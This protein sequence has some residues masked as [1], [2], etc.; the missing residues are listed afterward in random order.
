MPTLRILADGRWIAATPTTP[1]Y[2]DL[3]SF[4]AGSADTVMLTVDYTAW[5]GASAMAS[6]VW[7]VTGGT[8]VTQTNAAPLATVTV[9]L[10]TLPAVTDPLDFRAY[11]QA[12]IL[13]NTYATADGRVIHTTARLVAQPR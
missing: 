4:V 9:T 3:P 5:I 10:P 6:S 13:R 12:V 11:P 8:I 2:S 7:N 1:D